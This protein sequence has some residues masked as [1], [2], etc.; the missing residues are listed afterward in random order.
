MAAARRR[1]GAMTRLGDAMALHPSLQ[2]QVCE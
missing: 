1:A 2:V